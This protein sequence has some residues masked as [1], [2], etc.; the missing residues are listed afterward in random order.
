MAP[1]LWLIG[2][3]LA[4]LAYKVAT[5]KPASKPQ[6]AQPFPVP[7]IPNMPGFPQP[8]QSSFQP[9]Q[10]VKAP[11]SAV[12]SL[13]PQPMLA[14]FQSTGSVGVII[15]VTAVTGNIVMGN[16]VSTFDPNNDPIMMPTPIPVAVPANVV[17]A[18]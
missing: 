16:V 15:Q 6:P 1:L 14:T 7:T 17:T 5:D 8:A 2:A 18:A 13:L 4:A 10:R 3:G 12:A 9:G 11:L